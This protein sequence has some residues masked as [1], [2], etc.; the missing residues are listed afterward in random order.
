[1]KRLQINRKRSSLKFGPIFCPKLSEEQKKRTSLKFG[2]IFCT[3]LGEE[4]K[5][6]RSSL[7][8]G[9]IFCPKSGMDEGQGRKKF[10]PKLDATT[11]TLPDPP[12]PGFGYDVPPESPSRRP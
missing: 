7:K 6:K 8:F 3:K 5:K 2:P 4:Q 1:M 12:G 10:G 9:R 11:S